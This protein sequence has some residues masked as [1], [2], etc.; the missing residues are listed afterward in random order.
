MTMGALIMGV[1]AAEQEGMGNRVYFGSGVHVEQGLS[2]PN[3]HTHAIR[4]FES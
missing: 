2:N 4:R 1:S 3:T